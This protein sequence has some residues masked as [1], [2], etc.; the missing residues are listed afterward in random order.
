MDP[1]GAKDNLTY[2]GGEIIFWPVVFV[3]P[4]VGLFR[5]I[6]GGTGRWF[7]SIDIGIGL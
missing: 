2:A 1:W 5:S 7:A 3:G 4:R 6:N